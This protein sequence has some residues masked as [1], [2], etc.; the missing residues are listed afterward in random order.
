MAVI[1]T[2]TKFRVLDASGNPVNNAK[3][4]TYAAGT[5]TP[6]ATYTTQ[7]GNVANANPVRTEPDGTAEIWLG[8]GAYRF[9]VTDEDDVSLP[10]GDVDN[11]SA[12][13]SAVDLA[14]SDNANKGAGMVGFSRGPLYPH[15]TTGGEL[16]A[17]RRSLFQFMTAAQR[18]DVEA[19]TL[20]VDCTDAIQ[21]A[22]DSGE[23]L[24]GVI[25]S[26][27]LDGA[28]SSN[29][30]PNFVGFGKLTKFYSYITSG[31]ALE[32]PN[33]AIASFDDGI[34]L[35]DFLLIGTGSGS[36]IGLRAEGAVW[37][38]SGVKNVFIQSMGGAGFRFVD[39]IS[40]TVQFCRAQQ[41]GGGGFIIDQSNAIKL[42]GCSAESNGS[43][44]YNF[45]NT[46]IIGERIGC[47]LINCLS[48]ENVGDALRANEHDSLTILGGYYQVAALSSLDYA[49]IR[50]ISANN[51]SVIGAKLR[52]NQPFA[53]FSG[54]KL[55]GATHTKVIGNSFVKVGGGDGFDTNRDIVEDASSNRNV[56]IG[57]TGGGAQGEASYTT[58]ST[59]GSYYE[60]HAGSGGD[61]GME[62]RAG[63]HTFRDKSGNVIGRF[64][65]TDGVLLAQSGGKVGFYGGTPAAK[66]SVAAAASDA[67]TT[68]TLANSLR[69]ALIALNL[70]S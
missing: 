49:A 13:V 20:L 47:E 59:I 15:E 51:C 23:A 63:Y 11:I 27:R 54:V 5:T 2:G 48:E 14:T 24:E 4:H 55:E 44:G 31:V 34:I 17:K 69:T 46:G 43:H 30:V 19:G 6:K 21:D 35:R 56:F 9:V 10:D 1:I 65:P 12:P 61:Y 45:T 68:Q 22:F 40:S 29:V 18:S 62:R 66:P 39:C 60:N 36:A 64:H 8:S 33:N 57:N 28:I 70:V 38:I 25:G 42:I 32:I 26:I 37:P 58:S 67:A 53:L 52:T 50:L 7:A 41:C 16:R 3:I